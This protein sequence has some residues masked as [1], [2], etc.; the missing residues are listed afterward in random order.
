[1]YIYK[2]SQQDLE[3]CK[4][5]KKHTKKHTLILTHLGAVCHGVK[6]VFD[7]FR[8]RP[9]A[10]QHPGAVEF[11]EDFFHVVART[12]SRSIRQHA[13][14]KAS[15]LGSGNGIC[16][17]E[18]SSNLTK[19]LTDALF[20]RLCDNIEFGPT[21]YSFGWSAAVNRNRRAPKCTCRLCVRSMAFFLWAV[22]LLP[23]NQVRQ[24]RAKD[25]RH[26][27]YVGGF[28]VNPSLLPGYRTAS[29]FSWGKVAEVLYSPQ[30]ATGN[31]G[32]ENKG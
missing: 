19:W 22:D 25:V 32:T 3:K 13:W 24:P 30:K 2:A 12:R 6:D 8:A 17:P 11:I 4:L 29:L 7:H 20:I 9:V 31:R 23:H 26:R 1:M 18:L 27:P 21:T 28:F 5:Q 10:R 16:S 14:W 15:S